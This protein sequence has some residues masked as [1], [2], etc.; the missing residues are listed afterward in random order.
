MS[1]L[2][3]GSLV[4]IAFAGIVAG[5]PR[6][7]VRRRPVKPE[8]TYVLQKGKVVGAAS[9]VPYT[10]DGNIK[11]VYVPEAILEPVEESNEMSILRKRD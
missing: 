11:Q 7:A 10:T 6:H 2:V 4:M 9:S 8:V 5:N 1:K 3:I